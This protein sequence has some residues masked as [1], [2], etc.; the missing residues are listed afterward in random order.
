MKEENGYLSDWSMWTFENN[1]LPV[2]LWG[3]ERASRNEH[4]DTRNQFV[5]LIKAYSIPGVFLIESLDGT[6]QIDRCFPLSYRLATERE[7]E[8][9]NNPNANI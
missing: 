5:R 9:L 7:L 3:G 4:F 2:I 1:K 6:K 8:L